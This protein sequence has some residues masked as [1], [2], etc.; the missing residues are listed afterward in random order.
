MLFCNSAVSS[1]VASQAA[2]SV[3]TV[4]STVCAQRR[5]QNAATRLYAS[6]VSPSYVSRN[7]GPSRSPRR[8]R[9]GRSCHQKVHGIAEHR[10]AARQRQPR[11]RV[12]VR[13]ETSVV[14]QA[15]P[16]SASLRSMVGTTVPLR[17]L[18]WFQPNPDFPT[19]KDVTG[20]TTVHWN[21]RF[22]QWVQIWWNH[23]FSLITSAI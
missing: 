2:C 6:P 21:L 13:V 20:P 8:L 15:P 17:S 18:P 5:S 23:P 14:P 1:L 19:K 16:H 9:H 22:Q 12:C 10:A 4:V 3:S 7:R 11:A